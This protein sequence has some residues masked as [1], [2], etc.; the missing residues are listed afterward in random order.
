MI[1]FVAVSPLISFRNGAPRHRGAFNS[2]FQLCLGCGIL[3]AYLVNYNIEK[4]KGGWGWRVSLGLAA[5]PASILTISTPFLPETPNSLV[6]QGQS[7]KSQEN[8][9]ENSRHC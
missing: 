2:G 9:A 1:N 5:V 6:Q 3:I 8:A 4:I 7:R